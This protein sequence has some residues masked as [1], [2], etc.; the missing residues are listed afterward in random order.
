MTRRLDDGQ[1]RPRG[2]VLKAVLGLCALLLLLV[3]A[4]LARPQWALAYLPTATSGMPAVA[5]LAANATPLVA[6][7]SAAVALLCLLALH[8]AG[9]AAAPPVEPAVPGGLTEMERLRRQIAP[10][11]TGDLAIQLPDQEGAFGEVTGTLNLLL[12]GVSDLARAADEVAVQLLA[13]GQD[14][15]AGA[16][17]LQA[18]GARG[19]LVA[20]DLAEQARQ[21]VASTRALAERIKGAELSAGKNSRRAPAEAAAGAAAQPSVAAGVAGIVEVV[22]DL[23]EQAHVLAVEIRIEG[24]SGTAQGALQAIGDELQRLAERAAA[25]VRRI[26]PLAEAVGPAPGDGAAG[27]R[28][29]VSTR[30]AAGLTAA[31]ASLADQL[32]ALPEAATRLQDVSSRVER[33]SDDM[34]AAVDSFAEL[35][36]RLRRASGRFRVS[37]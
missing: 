8:R 14:L 33:A 34:L 32:A 27:D 2:G 15:R 23:A 6:L 31:A 13:L 28:L 9:R 29:G 5:W 11:A 3:A 22:A 7:A 10:L 36:R 37:S 17:R 18:E 4:L 35:A 24:A 20:T 16:D 30:Q 21:A 1:R 26:E 25:A 19:E 12:G